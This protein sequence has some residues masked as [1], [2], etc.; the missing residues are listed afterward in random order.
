M[1]HQVQKG[2][3]VLQ[4]NQV[5]MVKLVHLEVKDN[6]DLMDRQELLGSEVLQD[7]Q[8]Q[9]VKRVSLENK[10]L[11]DREVQQGLQEPQV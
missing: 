8:D 5:Q 9:R 11:L 4:D 7:P 2:C 6:Q 10:D 3:K 1:E